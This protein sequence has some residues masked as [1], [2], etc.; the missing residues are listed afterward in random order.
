VEPLTDSQAWNQFGCLVGWR[1]NDEKLLPD[2]K[3]SFS[4]K[5]PSG[6][7]PRTRLWLHGG[8]ANSVKQ[9]VALMERVGQLE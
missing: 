9:F 4:V 8:F 3:L 1:G 7:F 6:C 2:T 5:A